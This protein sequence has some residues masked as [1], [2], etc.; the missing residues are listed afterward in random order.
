MQVLVRDNN[1]DQALRVLKKKMQREGI[2]R[3]MKQRK[4]Y[5][6]PSEKKAREKAEAVRRARKAARKQMQRE[7]LLPAPKKVV[8]PTRAPRSAA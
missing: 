2:L 5:E 1:V 3:E 4:A 6:K 7:G 8:K